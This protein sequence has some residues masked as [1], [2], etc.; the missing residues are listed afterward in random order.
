MA[1][2]QACRVMRVLDDVERVLA[3]TRRIGFM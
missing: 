3:G 2:L 1:F